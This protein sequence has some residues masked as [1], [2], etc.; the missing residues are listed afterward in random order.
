VYLGGVIT[1]DLSCDKDHKDVARRIGLAAGIV[2]NLHEIW[3]A[4][5]I[6]K[7]TKVLLYQTLV[8]AIILYNSETWTLKEEQKRKLRVFEMSVLRKIGGIT[9]RDRRRN[10]DVLKEL[11]IEKDIVQVLQTR[12]L[13]YFGHVNRMQMERYPGV[14]LHGYTHGHRPK[15]RPKKKWIDN[16]REDCSDMDIS[17]H[18][19]SRLTSDRKSCWRNTVQHMGCQRAVS[20][21]SSQRQLEKAAQGKCCPMRSIGLRA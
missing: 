21:P 16:I 4:N 7:S 2:R 6:S 9:R 12:R 14:L 18:E 1:E 19:A 11:S 20:S 8:R 13:T 15:G 3:N 10:V 5:D 17:L